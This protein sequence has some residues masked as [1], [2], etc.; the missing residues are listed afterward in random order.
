LALEPLWLLQAVREVS[1]LADDQAPPEVS[2]RAFDSARIQSVSFARIPRAKRI[3]AQLQMPWREIL[4]LAHEPAH[5]HAHRLGRIHTEPEHDWLT[6]ELIA[7]ALQFV[8]L[9]LGLPSISPVQYRIEREKLL[10]EDR[11]AYLHG[12][13][14]RMPSENQIR[15]AMDG[16]WDAALALAHLAPRPQPGEQGRGKYAPTTAEVLERAFEAHG[17]EPTSKEIRY[18]TGR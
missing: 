7:F 4:A 6:D 13:Q 5:T 1:R 16:D 3:A 12:R 10:R 18:P 9:R 17:T 2:Q 8:A 15:V 14:L 11:A